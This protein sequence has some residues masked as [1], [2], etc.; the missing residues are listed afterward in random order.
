MRFL[1]TDKNTPRMSYFTTA[2][3]AA[4]NAETVPNGYT[5]LLYTSRCV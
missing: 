2:T 5:C 1:N 4:L 3:T